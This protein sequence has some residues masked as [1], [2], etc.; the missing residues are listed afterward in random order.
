LPSMTVDLKTEYSVIQLSVSLYL[1]FTA[2]V[3]FI[4][5]PLS[6]RFGR[7]PTALWS[8]SVFIFASIGCYFATSIEVFL[9]FR[10]IQAFVAI[11]MVI[12]R[13]VVR[14]IFSQDEAASKIGYVT[15]GMALVPMFAPMI[16]GMLDGMFGWRSIFIF[17]TAF[18]FLLLIVI[19]FDQGETASSTGK[20]LFEQFQE[21]PELFASRRFWGYVLAATFS[22]GTFFAFLGGAPYVATHVFKLSSSQTG[23]LFG[24]PATG[25]LVGNLLTGIYSKRLGINPMILAGA[26]LLTLGMASSLILTLMG[27]GSPLVF[28]GFCILVGLGNG[29]TLPNATAGMLSVRPRIAG[30]ASGIGG[31]IMIGGGAA[32]SALA[33]ALLER[34]NGSY[35]WQLIMLT[36]AILCLI[37]ILYVIQ[38]AKTIAE[39]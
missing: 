33:G 31:A 35:P 7:R 19:W 12:S 32:L 30:T 3:Q 16:G 36:S 6:D 4:V 24:I 2:L 15:M 37:S 5:G 22:S 20:S 18:G 29:L 21:Y 28:F 14:D 26:S 27:Y 17:M 39:T 23:L 34:G 10:M 8:I 1:A 11:G 13:A 25:Y 38:R 9:T